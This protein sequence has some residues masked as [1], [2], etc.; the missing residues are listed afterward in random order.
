MAIWERFESVCWG[1]RL[2]QLATVVLVV[3]PIEVDTD[4]VLA[5]RGPRSGSRPG[6]ASTVHSLVEVNL[7]EGKLMNILHILDLSNLPR[8]LRAHCPCQSVQQ[9][10]WCSPGHPGCRDSPFCTPWVREDRSAGA[11]GPPPYFPWHIQNNSLSSLWFQAHTDNH[12]TGRDVGH[13][14]P[15]KETP[16]GSWHPLNSL[17]IRVWRNRLSKGDN[18]C[19]ITPTWLTNTII[20]TEVAVGVLI[21]AKVLAHLAVHVLT[22]SRTW[23]NWPGLKSIDC[24]HK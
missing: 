13:R 10:H 16:F 12:N 11:G 22:A 2:S 1:E 21:V 20:I 18:L 15:R 24:P 4:G 23:C 19:Q 14:K 9:I 8:N 7:V 3:V 6:D 5:L 17:R